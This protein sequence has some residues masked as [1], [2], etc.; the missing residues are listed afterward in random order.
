MLKAVANGFVSVKFVD[1]YA[2]IEVEVDRVRLLRVDD[3]Q[4]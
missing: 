1:E 4:G 3:G 2:P